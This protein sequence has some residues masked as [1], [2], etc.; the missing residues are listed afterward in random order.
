LEMV[1]TPVERTLSATATQEYKALIATLRSNIGVIV[2]EWAAASSRST[3][4]R[5]TEFGLPQQERVD[6]L[7]TFLEALLDRAEDPSDKMALMSLKC[8]IR[9]EHAR[10]LN[11]STLIKRQRLLRDVL[12]KVI[13][14]EIPHLSKTSA[15]LAVDAIVDKSIEGTVVMLEEYS[16]LQSVLTRWMLAGPGE[17]TAIEQSFA[18]FCRNAMDYFDIEFT[19]LFKY[20]SEAKEL[21]CQACSARDVTLSKDSRIPLK[22]LSIAEEA[23]EQNRTIVLD[24]VG[25]KPQ[26]KRKI[27]GQVSFAHTVL[28]P[29]TRDGERVGMIIFGDNSRPNAFTPDEVGIAEDL[30]KQIVRVKENSEL[31]QKLSLRSRAQKVLVDTAALLQQEIESEEI[32]RIVATRLAELVPCQELAF[33]VYDWERRVGNPVY[34]AGPY[35]SEM[36]ADRDFPADIGIAGYVAQT[37]KAEIVLDTETDPRG[38]LIPG[39]P[40][41]KTR[42]L[43]VPVIGQK[44][45]IG[46][47][48]LM[49]YPPETFNQEDVEIATMFAN[50]ASVALQNAK[51]LKEVMRVRDQIE[52]S[53]DLLTHDI[54]N[55]TTPIN[56]YFSE[57]MSW[58][59][60]DPRVADI[61]DK[62]GKQ[63][64]SITRLV[65]MVRTLARLREAGPQVFKKMDLRKAIDESV[66]DVRS[67][68]SSKEI[69]F[70]MFFP[71]E[72]MLVLADDMLKEIFTNLFYSAAMSDRQSQTTLTVT[73]EIKKDRKIEYWWIKVAQPSKAIPENLKGE[74]LRMAKSS[75]SELTGGFGIGLAAARSIVNRY[76]GGMWVSDI[77]QGDYSKG[78]VFNIMLPKTR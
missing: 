56:A 20:D 34:A 58:P 10:S 42:M 45:V 9:S 61:I 77:V 57:L 47:I 74:V 25:A 53:M 43:A 27:I 11:L 16:E 55:Y 33:Y 44:E 4:A 52:L 63:V 2:E 59:D 17:E 48:E 7:R 66:A 69:E 19:A 30:A 14:K 72:D 3:Y 12:Y 36:M 64:E 76:A 40:K 32:Y 31:F 51:L 49:R 1:P 15:K 38:E 8:S 78:C 54:A 21:V 29:M 26:K 22:G 73:G 24:D 6:R 35:A 71:G 65:E 23:F 41:T 50:H 18:R 13:L 68:T 39:T 75:K 28:V 60:L 67:H 62:T 5:G 46:V 70:E 37:R